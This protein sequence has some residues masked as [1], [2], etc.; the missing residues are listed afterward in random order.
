MPNYMSMLGDYLV[1]SYNLQLKRKG[2]LED[3]ALSR[4]DFG[5]YLT[6]P[7]CQNSNK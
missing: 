7:V 4:V 6:K 3:C 5:V 2:L 1:Y